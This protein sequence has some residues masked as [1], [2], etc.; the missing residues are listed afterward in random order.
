MNDLNP[1]NGIITLIKTPGN[2]EYNVVF[3]N[4]YDVMV[5]GGVGGGII[6]DYN[7]AGLNI[8]TNDPSVETTL[9][10]DGEK[11]DI[12]S[13]KKYDAL[14]LSYTKDRKNL[15]IE[16]VRNTV[17]GKGLEISESY[18]K[19]GRKA[20]PVTAA[21]KKYSKKLTVGAETE[22]IL[23]KSGFAVGFR[24]AVSPNERYG[25]FMGMFIDE[26]IDEYKNK[27]SYR[28]GGN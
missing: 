8:N 6:Y 3:V 16:I 5:A 21:F 20:Y 9:I 27:A 18:I 10:L 26:S 17:S 25:Y 13:I 22:L 7:S 28:G 12:N 4:E 2:A 19:V 14:M 1:E 23:D 11:P 15:T 24:R